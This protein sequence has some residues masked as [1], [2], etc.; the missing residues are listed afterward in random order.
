MKGSLASEGLSDVDNVVQALEVAEDI[1]R[2]GVH[3]FLPKV[4]D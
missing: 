4:F 2:F 3:Q 1:E